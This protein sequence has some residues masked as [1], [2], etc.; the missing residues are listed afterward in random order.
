MA[1]KPRKPTSAATPAFS[2]GSGPPRPCRAAGVQREAM[3][4]DPE[5]GGA[6]DGLGYG[7]QVTVADVGGAAARRADDVV[8]VI[9]PACDVGVLAGGGGGG[10]EGVGVDG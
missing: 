2:A 9:R 10:R 8:V 4:G 3:G 5:P 1:E 6:F 7:G